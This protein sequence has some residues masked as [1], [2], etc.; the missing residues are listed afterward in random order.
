MWYEIKTK[1]GHCGLPVESPWLQ[2]FP[3]LTKGR[4]GSFFFVIR[5]DV[6]KICLKKNGLGLQR[7]PISWRQRFILCRMFLNFVKIYHKAKNLSMFPYL[8]LYYNML[9]NWFEW[10]ICCINCYYPTLKYHVHL[11]FILCIF[12]LSRNKWNEMILK[13]LIF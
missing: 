6:F 13:V 9:T 5:N 4:C 10:Y 8:P 12:L 7:I 11:I 2:L 3:F 1:L